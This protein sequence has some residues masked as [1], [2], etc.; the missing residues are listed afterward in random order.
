M[1]DITE[2]KKMLEAKKELMMNCHLRYGCSLR[3]EYDDEVN[4]PN[5]DEFLTSPFDT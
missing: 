3:F 4:R 5:Q 1:K 2:Y